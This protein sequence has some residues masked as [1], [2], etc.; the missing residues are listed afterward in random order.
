VKRVIERLVGSN[1]FATLCLSPVDHL[2]SVGMEDLARDIGGVLKSQ[3]DITG[4]NLFRLAW[5][6][7][8][9]IL[10]KSFHVL[11]GESRWNQRGPDRTRSDPPF[12]LIPFLASE[13]ESER[14]KDTIAPLVEE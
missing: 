2:A 4:C 14:V 11:F 8:R 10:A 3:E 9:H 1:S 13:R 7:E 5:P 6:L 12:T